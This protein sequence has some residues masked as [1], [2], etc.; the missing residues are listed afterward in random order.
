MFYFFQNN[1]AQNSFTYQ[2]EFQNPS[3]DVLYEFRVSASYRP[4]IGTELA[5][6]LESCQIS[7]VPPRP[8]PPVNVTV[9]SSSITVHDPSSFVVSF[10]L[11]LQQPNE[12]SAR[13]SDL[14]HEYIITTA[15]LAINST[16]QDG[17]MSISTTLIN[18]H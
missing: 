11:M 4:G 1:N 8:S 12:T 18:V 5:P 16:N 10:D 13:I 6:L 14:R 2:G 15:P 7:L 17:V 9:Q 3:N